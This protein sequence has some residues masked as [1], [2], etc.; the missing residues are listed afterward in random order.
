[1]SNE[2]G[3]AV[4]SDSTL[5]SRKLVG[6][7]SLLGVIFFWVAQSEV[8][9]WAQKAYNKPF[10]ISWFNH[11]VGILLVPVLYLLLGGSTSQL[12]LVFDEL[13]GN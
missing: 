10:F 2:G 4:G 7:L 1:M 13:Q 3:A 11:S 9:Q 8:A 5:S 12:K 6:Y